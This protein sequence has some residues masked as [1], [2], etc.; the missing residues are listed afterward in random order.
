EPE[1]IASTVLFL[2]SDEAAHIQGQELF[3]DGGVTSSPAG[4]PIYR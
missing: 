2:A 4:A 3:V 1:N